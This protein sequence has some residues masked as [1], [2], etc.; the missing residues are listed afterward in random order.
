[1]EIY[2]SETCI[3]SK[4]SIIDTLPLGHYRYTS[5]I[6]PI[7]GLVISRV[8]IVSVLRNSKLLLVYSQF[9]PPKMISFY[10]LLSAGGPLFFHLTGTPALFSL[11]N[12]YRT[13]HPEKT[14]VKRDMSRS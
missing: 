9:L 12:A 10:Y 1:M 6:F 4:L 2:L 3:Y 7:S 13:C 5:F 11:T 8:D 14:G